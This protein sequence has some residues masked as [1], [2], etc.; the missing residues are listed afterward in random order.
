[1]LFFAQMFYADLY[2]MRSDARQLVMNHERINRRVAAV[3]ERKLFTHEDWKTVVKNVDERID[4]GELHQ[5]ERSKAQKHAKAGM[6]ELARYVYRINLYSQKSMI[7]TQVYRGD[8][9][10]KLLGAETVRDVRRVCGKL[11]LDGSGKD[12]HFEAATSQRLGWP[13]RAGSP[14]PGYLCKYSETFIAAKT[15]PRYPKSHRPSTQLKQLWF[16]ARA[17][18]GALFGVSTRTA[19]NLMP[20]PAPRP[21]QASVGPKTITKSKEMH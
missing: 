15:H 13:L 7:K 3:P 1:M 5:W 20:L 11:Y 16:L 19:L 6:V 9:L 18:S 4:R 21:K 10:A 14:L 2:S 17:L 12:A 8:I